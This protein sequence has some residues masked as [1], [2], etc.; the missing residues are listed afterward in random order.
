MANKRIYGLTEQETYAG[1][2]FLAVD[3]SSLTEAK[4]IK[5]STVAPK[6]DTLTA[7]SG[8]NIAQYLVRLNNGAGA[9]TKS[10]IRAFFDLLG[11]S[12][13]STLL[14]DENGTL[15]MTMYA[16]RFDK[17]VVLMYKNNKAGIDGDLNIMYD[18]ASGSSGDQYFLPETLRPANTVRNNGV[19]GV[20]IGTDGAVSQY[21]HSTVRSEYFPMVYLTA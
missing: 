17:I 20:L 14:Y 8:V 11:E 2:L 4:K 7:A 21:L 15:T 1:D 10:T 9:E 18:S 6:I 19:P 5:V 12:I 3:E 13:E 16:F